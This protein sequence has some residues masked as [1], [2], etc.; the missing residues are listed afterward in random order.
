MALALPHR[1][2]VCVCASILVLVASILELV[3][4]VSV[5]VAS[6]FVSV[7]SVSVSVASVSVSV[8]NVSVS[9]ASVSV[10]VANVS[11]SVANVSVSVASVCVANGW[12]EL[13]SLL[14]MRA[15]QL[16]LGLACNLPAQCD[17]LSALR[18]CVC[19]GASV[20][21]CMSSSYLPRKFIATSK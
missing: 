13:Q 21:P 12:R 9:V 2:C 4:R 20:A 8:A 11:V 1:Q 6:I 3:A 17:M 16:A 5:S 7:A 15:L 19:T 10:F 18:A 14:Q